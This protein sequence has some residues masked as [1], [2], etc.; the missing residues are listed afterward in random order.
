MKLDLKVENMEF[1]FYFSDLPMLKQLDI[2]YSTLYGNL[3]NDRP[4]NYLYFISCHPFTC[5]H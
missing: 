3:E 4:P 1:A 2:D 5:D